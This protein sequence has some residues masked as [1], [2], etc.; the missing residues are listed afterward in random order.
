VVLTPIVLALLSSS[1]PPLVELFSSEGCSSCPP[2]EALVAAQAAIAPSPVILEWHVDYWNSLGW[3]DPFSTAEASE[4][5]GR[6]AR[7]GATDQVYT[8]QAIVDGRDSFVGSD[9]AK[10]R[11]ALKRAGAAEKAALRLEL[12]GTTLAI[13]AAEAPAGE[14][15]VAVTEAGLETKVERGENAGRTLRHAP[16]VR[17]FQALGRT[18]AGT[19]ARQVILWLEPGWR[20]ENVRLVVAIQD[21]ES[22]RILALG[23]TRPTD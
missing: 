16:V 4:R 10:L 6:Y 21:P 8:P 20:R 19:L 3:R 1:A 13:D 2:A 11:A 18:A 5:Q 14:L 15:W 9:A 7:W 17:H 22:G 23:A 12:R